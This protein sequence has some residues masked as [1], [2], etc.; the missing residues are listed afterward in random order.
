MGGWRDHPRSRGEYLQ[1]EQG[2]GFEDGSSP[3]SRGILRH[4]VSHPRARRIIPALAGNTSGVSHDLLSG[5]DHPRSRGEYRPEP[6]QRGHGIGS[7]P[8]SRG[9]LRASPPRH[10]PSRIIPALAGNTARAGP[11]RPGV[12]DHPRSRGEYG[13]PWACATQLPGSSPLSRG[14]RTVITPDGDLIGIIPA[15]AG[16]T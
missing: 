8:L 16:N 7:S 15:L 4:V 1:N 3:L 11:A 14:I 12:S 6:W 5:W 9:I 2:V 10:W 13:T